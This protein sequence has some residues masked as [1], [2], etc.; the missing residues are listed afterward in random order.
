MTLNEYNK[1][2]FRRCP[3]AKRNIVQILKSF[4]DI[5]DIHVSDIDKTIRVPARKITA[6]SVEELNVL[7]RLEHSFGYVSQVEN[8]YL[9]YKY[10]YL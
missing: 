5:S 2:R 10:S 9:I 8:D 3:S 6:L 7:C 4:F 1:I